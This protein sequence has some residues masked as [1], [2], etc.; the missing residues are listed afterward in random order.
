[1]IEIPNITGKT[2]LFN[3]IINGK[4]KEPLHAYQVLHNN[5]TKTTHLPILAKINYAT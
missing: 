3:R 2:N 1:M 5:T 4:C